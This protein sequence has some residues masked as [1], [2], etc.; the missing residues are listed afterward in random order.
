MLGIVA[1]GQLMVTGVYDVRALKFEEQNGVSVLCRP[2]MEANSPFSPEVSSSRGSPVLVFK[3]QIVN[4]T[5]VNFEL[6]TP[7]TPS[8]ILRCNSTQ[9]SYLSGLAKWFQPRASTSKDKITEVAEQD[10]DRWCTWSRGS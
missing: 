3:N 5:R 10:P 8:D 9:D 7:M 4:S 1:N 6:A 2:P